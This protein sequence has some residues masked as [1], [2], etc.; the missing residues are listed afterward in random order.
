MALPTV[1]DTHRFVYAFQGQ[2][3]NILPT[4]N[5]SSTI[6]QGVTNILG[7]VCVCVIA[8]L[9]AHIGCKVFYR[10]ILRGYFK[11][12]S[13]TSSKSTIY[14][15]LTVIGYFA[16]AWVLGSAIPNITDLNTI[17]G[18]ACILQFTYTFPPMLLVG[19]WV[20]RDAIA[21]D[22]PWQPGI[23]PWS[24]RVD[25]WWCLSRWKRGFRRH[26]YAKITLVSFCKE[27]PLIQDLHVPRM[28]R[29]VRTWYLLWSPDCQGLV[30]ERIHYI[31][32]VPSS[33]P[34]AVD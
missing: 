13:L 3:T 33:R 11:A 7:L 17:V 5:I 22:N 25:T 20:Q 29:A 2:Y 30:C 28:S 34:A 24:N 31:L 6:F 21:G 18:A 1:T 23:E 26:W 15:C 9:Y 10:N 8:I 16:L 32:L 12:P 4:V 14:W 19:H 27:M